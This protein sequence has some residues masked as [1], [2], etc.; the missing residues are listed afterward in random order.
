[1]VSQLYDNK[2]YIK[3]K[4]VITNVSP[5]RLHRTHVIIQ[6]PY[7]HIEYADQLRNKDITTGI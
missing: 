7:S 1:M 3:K 6:V 5:I 2:I 4:E